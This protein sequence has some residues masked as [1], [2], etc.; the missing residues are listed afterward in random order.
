VSRETSAK[1]LGVNDD[2][3]SLAAAGGPQGAGVSRSEA[4]FVRDTL[5]WSTLVELLRFFG[6]FGCGSG[7]GQSSRSIAAV[8]V[9]LSAGEVKPR[10]RDGTSIAGGVPTPVAAPENRSLCAPR[11]WIH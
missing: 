2:D 9:V 10:A 5:P 11:K 7:L 4:V 6:C 8:A 1:A 3:V